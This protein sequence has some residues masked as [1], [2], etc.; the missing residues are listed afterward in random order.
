MGAILNRAYKNLPA[1]FGEPLHLRHFSITHPVF[2]RAQNDI[3]TQD[4]PPH[5]ALSDARGLMAGYRAWLSFMKK[6]WRIESHASGFN[7]FTVG[8]KVRIAPQRDGIPKTI[9]SEEREAMQTDDA[10]RKRNNGLG[11]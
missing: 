9:I 6:I 4:W 7:R 8:N 2:E 10:E 1:N 3:Y 5:H 11:R